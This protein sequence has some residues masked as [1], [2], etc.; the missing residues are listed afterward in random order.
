MPWIK[1][2]V[3][4]NIFSSIM[5]TIGLESDIKHYRQSLKW[6]CICRC[7]KAYA[8]KG[9]LANNSILNFHNGII[10]PWRLAQYQLAVHCCSV[11]SKSLINLLPDRAFMCTFILPYFLWFLELPREEGVLSEIGQSTLKYS[12]LGVFAITKAERCQMPWN[13]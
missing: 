9:M 11:L 8:K 6:I 1:I 2:L 5:N 7:Q 4:F 13:Q 3:G 12:G 10:K